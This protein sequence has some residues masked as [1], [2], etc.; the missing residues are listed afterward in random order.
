MKFKVTSE[1]IGV[2][3]GSVDDNA[4][5]SCMY[6]LGAFPADTA[7]STRNRDMDMTLWGTRTPEHQ[8]LATVE[9]EKGG[10]RRRAIGL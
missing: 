3:L 2:L 5:R 8:A 9:P 7:P 6:L 1:T 4:R 10:S